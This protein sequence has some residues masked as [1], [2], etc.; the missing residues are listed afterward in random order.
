MGLPTAGTRHSFKTCERFHFQNWFKMGDIKMRQQ[1]F[2]DL[3]VRNAQILHHDNLTNNH[4]VIYLMDAR[5]LFD[6]SLLNKI[7]MLLNQ[8]KTVIRRWIATYFHDEKYVII[9][10][11]MENN[12]LVL[13][14]KSKSL[15]IRE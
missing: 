2:Q 8:N 14:H 15:K 1:N 11:E 5:V 9:R 3:S 6:V 10:V 4:T 12:N 7:R 13:I